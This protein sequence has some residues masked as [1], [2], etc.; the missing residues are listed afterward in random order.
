MIKNNKNLVIFQGGKAK[1]NLRRG[2]A[3]MTPSSRRSVHTLCC[4]LVSVQDETLLI[5]TKQIILH[6]LN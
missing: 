1:A 3:R 4:V 2:V 6:Y 5:E